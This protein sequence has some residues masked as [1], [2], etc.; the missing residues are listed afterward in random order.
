MREPKDVKI[1]N[2]TLQEVIE[3]HQHYIKRDCT[4]WQNM[5]ANLSGADLHNTNLEYVNLWGA[6]LSYSNLKGANLKY[7]ILAYSNLCGTSLRYTNLYCA[8]LCCSILSDSDLSKAD[9]QYAN[10]T[11]C[12]LSYADLHN[13]SLHNSILRYSTLTGAILDNANFTEAS[14]HNSILIDTSLNDTCFLRANLAHTVMNNADGKQIEYIKGKILTEP[15]IGYKKCTNYYYKKDPTD[16]MRD[17]TVTLEI[18]RGAI[19]FS[20]NGGK[21]RTNRAKVIDI[22]G[23]NRA[24]SF[25]KYMTYYVGDEFTIYNFNCEYNMECGEGIHF[26][27]TREEAEAY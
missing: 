12:D 25:H 21:C 22:E 10:L 14:L 17:I 1:D 4:G 15:L 23:A 20:V 16:V 3:R 26:F 5:C 13:A 9:L 19:V 7:A 8:N 2:I 6:D 24:F 11:D 27:L 18:P